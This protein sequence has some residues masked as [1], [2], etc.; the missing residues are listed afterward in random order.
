VG[1]APR[2]ALST[3]G[4]ALHRLGRLVDRRRTVRIL[5]YHSVSDDPVRSSVSPAEFERQIAH[6]HRQGYDVLRLSDA[7]A[8]LAGGRPV[9]TRAIV[10]TLDDGF[11]DNYE[12]A[13]PVLERFRIPATIFLTAGYI[14]TD[15]LP[16][17]TRTA[18]V[19]RPLTWEQIREMHARGIEFG[20]HTLT[21]PMLAQV[22]ADEARR[23][24]AESRALIEDRL[25]ARVS[26]FCYP[27]GDHDIR[28][29]RL[30]AEC[31]YD[32]ACTTIPGVNGQGADLL[33]LRRTYISRR[34]TTA[35]FAK[36]VAGAYDLLQQ[37]ALGWHRLRVGRRAGRRSPTVRQR[38]DGG[39]SGAGAG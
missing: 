28:V 19:P 5:Y 34:D 23:E 20:S 25:G 27:R 9:P 26:L 16:T 7:V 10:L 22:P 21:H 18:F 39:G 12:R 33:A 4:L 3:V 14:G 11:R 29:K 1:S 35:E 24:I 2:A 32:A 37:A 17:L 38:V 31:G 15:R 13:F 30:V 8:A 6:L 36:K